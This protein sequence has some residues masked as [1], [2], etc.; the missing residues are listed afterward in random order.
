[1]SNPQEL[2][3]FLMTW[4]KKTIR[5][6]D[7]KNFIDKNSPASRYG[8][9]KRALKS[10]Y[11]L[12]LRRG[13]YLIEKPFNESI[14]NLFE[15]AQTLYGPS[16]ISL[17]SAL[18]YHQW[19]PEAVYTVTSVTAKRSAKFGTPIGQFNFNHIPAQDLYL[20]VER[21]AT[22]AGE[23]YFMA[24]PWRAIADCIY[25][26]KKKWHNLRSISL[27]LR[28]AWETLLESDNKTLQ[29][30]SENYPSARVRKLLNQYLEEFS[31]A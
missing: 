5:D 13:F 26:Y 28:V 23:I 19:I 3:K 4:P 27:D 12:K 21:I 10:H 16:H 6:V 8:I 15:I 31:R 18:S 20:G 9:I 14:P 1:M 24:Q 25:V 11:L 30:L 7:F 2:R 22:P 29:L 17:E